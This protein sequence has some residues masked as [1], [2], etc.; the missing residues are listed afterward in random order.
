MAFIVAL[1]V[2]MLPVAGT[3]AIAVKSTEMT[4]PAAAQ[5]TDMSVAMGD[6]CPDPAKPCDQAGKCQSMASCTQPC[7]SI[8]NISVSYLTYP[9]VAGS[10]L[11][12]LMDSAAPLHAGSPP[13]RPPRV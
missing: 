12:V 4:I 6:C 7:F 1:S 2:A 8:V 9:L 10:P 5:S 3:A 13:F 11:P